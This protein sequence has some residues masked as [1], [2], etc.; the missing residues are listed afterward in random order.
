MRVCHLQDSVSLVGLPG[1]YCG[2]SDRR[3]SQQIGVLFRLFRFAR[4]HLRQ[5]EFLGLLRMLR[6]VIE[7]HDIFVDGAD[8]AP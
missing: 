6:H 7:Q 4:Q 8:G 3:F 2:V 5:L 1:V